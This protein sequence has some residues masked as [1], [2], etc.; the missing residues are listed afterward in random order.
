MACKGTRGKAI[1][2]RGK[3]G[4]GRKTKKVRVVSRKGKGC[5]NC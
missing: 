5:K 4:A 3:S 2:K 1:P